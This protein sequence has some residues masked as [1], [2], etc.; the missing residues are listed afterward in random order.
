MRR[1]LRVTWQDMIPD[2][3]VL[4]KR[5]GLQSIHAL[6]EESSTSMG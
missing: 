4:K 6:T 1:L 5:A 3:E 2:T